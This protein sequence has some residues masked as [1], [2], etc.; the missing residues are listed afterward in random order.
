MEHNAEH[1]GE[2]RQWAREAGEAEAEML[3]A[4]EASQQVNATLSAAL[5]KL[6]GPLSH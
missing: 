5:E 4:A 2:F 6:G 1:A 3:T